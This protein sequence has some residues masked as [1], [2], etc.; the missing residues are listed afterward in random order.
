[1]EFSQVS[2]ESI[3]E[4]EVD[5]PSAS[6]PLPL[7]FV[8]PEDSYP[9]LR[10]RAGVVARAQAAIES[11]RDSIRVDSFWFSLRRVSVGVSSS[12]AQGGKSEFWL[13][14]TDTS[15]TG[16]STS[17]LRSSITFRNITLL[18]DSS[19]QWAGQTLQNWEISY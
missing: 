16:M 6:M 8:K 7:E 5:F 3:A 14:Q 13:N 11:G 17:F 1:M 10:R 12:P 9:F 18:K 15:Q 4:N 19:Y 2:V